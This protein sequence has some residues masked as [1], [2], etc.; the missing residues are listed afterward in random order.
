MVSISWWLQRPH[1]PFV[2]S[3]LS[4]YLVV[5][6]AAILHGRQRTCT[7]FTMKAL[8]LQ[9]PKPRKNTRMPSVRYACLAISIAPRGVVKVVPLCCAA[10]SKDCC[11]KLVERTCVWTRVLIT[12]KG[13]MEAHVTTPAKPPHN[14]TFTALC[15]SVSLW[16][17]IHCL[18][19]SYDQKLLSSAAEPRRLQF[20]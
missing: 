9:T 4:K 1:D 8:T 13:N 11:S 3:P 10:T 15:L 20:C 6:S 7:A 17:V 2:H 5:S 14:S 18:L 12:S 19:S 16:L